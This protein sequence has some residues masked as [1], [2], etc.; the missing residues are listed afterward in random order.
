MKR[1]VLYAAG[2]VVVLGNAFYWLAPYTIAASQPHWPGVGEVLHQYMRNAVAIRSRNK[3]VPRQIDLDDPGLVRLGAGHFATGCATCHG[4]PGIARNPITA[5]MMPAPPKLDGLDFTDGELWWIARHG[6]RYSGMP[7]W[8][9]EG[10]EVEPWAIAAFL[11]T[12]DDFDR[13]SYEES[14]LGSAYAGDAI[15]FPGL[16]GAIPKD[17]ACA[18]CHGED[19]LGRDGTAPK[20]AGQSRDWLALVLDAYHDGR[21]E[22]G[23][24]EP[25]GATLTESNIDGISE[26]YAEMDGNWSGRPLPFG[27]PER[28]AELARKGDEHNDIASCASCHEGGENPLMP[29]RAD[30]PRIAGQ[31]GF[32][33]YNW[34]LMYRDGPVPETPRAHLMAAAAK[35]L[36]DSDIADL[37]AYYAGL[38]EAAAGDDN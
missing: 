4:A 6:I 27:D 21:R 34:L 13:A 16:Y 33:L 24:M 12:Y 1:L 37:S 32:W 2:L 10:R 36:S 28:G 23:F 38:S 25:L 14:A 8:P 9:G 5:E 17:M 18:R 3:E 20:L 19:G 11:R 22:S 7:S 35:P 29:R 26:L 31:D 30:T 15:R